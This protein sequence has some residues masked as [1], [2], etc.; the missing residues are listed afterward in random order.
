MIGKQL[1]MNLND[2]YIPGKIEL[3]HQVRQHLKTTGYNDESL[4]ENLDI[5]FRYVSVTYDILYPHD[6]VHIHTHNFYEIALCESGNA[7]H[8]ADKQH[9]SI[10]KGDITILPPGIRHCPIGLHSMTEPYKRIIL[11]ISP[12]FLEKHLT[13]WPYYEKHR[14]LFKQPR[15]FQTLGTPHEKLWN[16]FKIAILENNPDSPY[17]DSFLCG[18]TE[19]LLTKLM[20]ATDTTLEPTIKHKQE[21]LENIVS[22]VESHLAEKI[23]LNDIITQFHVSKNSITRLFQNTMGCSFH[24]YVIHTRLDEAKKL[25]QKNINLDTIAELTGFGEYS[26]FYRAFKKEYHM[27]PSEYRSSLALL[28]SNFI[29]TQS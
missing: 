1:I 5:G 23:I 2:F 22:Y 13:I 28:N 26:N 29:N 11:L 7:Q 19:C 18:I 17:S 16:Y 25:L 21:L 20:S 14:T 12:V 15:H 3:P 8:L 10:Q 9:F 27:T 4:Y 6:T 24:D